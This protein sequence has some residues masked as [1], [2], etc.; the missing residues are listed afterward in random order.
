MYE[1][2]ISSVTTVGP[3]T[4]A[5]ELETPEDFAALPGQFVLVRAELEGEEISRHYTLSS[6]DVDGTFEITVG[7]DPGGDLSPWLADRRPGDTLSFEGPFGTITYEGEGDVVA[8]AGG[9]GIGPGVAIAEA[10]LAASH[11]A[12]VIYQDDTPA[13]RSRLNDLEE[14]GVPVT[15]LDEDETAALADAVGDHLNDG[16]I[17]A[18]GFK[19]FVDAVGDAISEAGGDPEAALIENFG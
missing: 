5:L 14:T 19:D 10:A 7:V 4:I 11:D 12:A 6:P 9:P 16:Q 2:S 1:T 18:F 3:E 13:H 8:I 15:V 17:Y